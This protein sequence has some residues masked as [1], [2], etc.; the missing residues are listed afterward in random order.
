M[1]I[2]RLLSLASSLLLAATASTT[3][4]KGLN[5]SYAEA[6]Y[7]YLDSDEFEAKKGATVRLSFGIMDHFHV[8]A[9][10]SYLDVNEH[11]RASNDPD[12]DR[13]VFGAGGHF[14]LTDNL[15]LTGT[16]SWVSREWSNGSTSGDT[17][18]FN[19]SDRGYQA[20]FGIR[21]LLTDRL[22]LHGAGSYLD[23]D[24]LDQSAG[25]IGGV[26]F[27][28]NKKFALSGSASHYPDADET[29]AFLGVRLNF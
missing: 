11:D 8:K 23:I 28:L 15:D 17:R 7:T 21:Y 25:V 26:V 14:S 29:E 16:L 2:K 9:A 12:L 13:F 3:Y 24:D 10:Y 6:G 27:K 5:Y 19:N 4:A 1:R 22:E 20:D 18:N